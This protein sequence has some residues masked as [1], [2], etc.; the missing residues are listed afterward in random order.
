[1]EPILKMVSERIKSLEEDQA[2]DLR[3]NFALFISATHKKTGT[4]DWLI[5]LVA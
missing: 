5:G 3:I 4:R 1:M 2:Y